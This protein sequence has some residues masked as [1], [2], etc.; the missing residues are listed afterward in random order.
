MDI[1]PVI[2]NVQWL[3]MEST[4]PTWEPKSASLVS[5][6]SDRSPERL[7]TGA[8]PGES[9]FFSINACPCSSMVFG[10]S[11]KPSLNERQ[12]QGLGNYCV[13]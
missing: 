9:L 10:R 1:S 7:W 3:E 13:G 6:V 12:C 5:A 11:M 4:E 8:V 2:T